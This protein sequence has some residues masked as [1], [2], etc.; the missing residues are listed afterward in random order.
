M[1]S[2]SAAAISNAV[3][4]LTRDDLIAFRQ[5]WLRPDK[6]T[7]FVVSDR[8]LAEVKA[9]LDARL[10]DWRMDGAGGTKGDS[11]RPRPPRP[12]SCWSIAPIR[13]NR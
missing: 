10:G 12:R 6:A 2:R 4:K 1:P 13:R 3:A 7:V 5:A 8:P 9:A 11:S